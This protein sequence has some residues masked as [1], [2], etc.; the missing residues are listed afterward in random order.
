MNYYIILLVLIPQLVWADNTL[1]FS[2]KKETKV[3]LYQ[4]EIYSNSLLKGYKR[5]INFEKWKLS[6]DQ[7]NEKALEFSMNMPVTQT[8]YFQTGNFMSFT[9]SVK[10]S[11]HK[12]TATLPVNM[13]GLFLP[14][15]KRLLIRLKNNIK[16][17]WRKLNLEC[18]KFPADLSQLDRIQVI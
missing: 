4:A 7:D 15:R 5:R 18:D 11:E 6:P 16:S 3:S 17:D 1:E 14:L 12:G 13:D 2:C 8:D 9:M 10:N